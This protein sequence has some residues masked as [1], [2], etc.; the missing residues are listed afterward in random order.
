MITHKMSRVSMIPTI[1]SKVLSHIYL[2]S[3]GENIGKIGCLDA[4]NNLNDIYTAKKEVRRKNE[5]NK[6]NN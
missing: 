1:F 6:E 4:E 2:Y 5:N 3:L